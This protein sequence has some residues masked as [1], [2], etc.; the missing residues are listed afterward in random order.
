MD[1]RGH[2]GNDGTENRNYVLYCS[3][4]YIYI[5]L[6]IGVLVG[7][8][9]RIVYYLIPDWV[10]E[11]DL[12][13]GCSNKEALLFTVYPC[14]CLVTYFNFVISNSDYSNSLY[15]GI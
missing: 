13:L 9:F 12:K 10:A 1:Y 4:V 15:K 2:T 11:K 14:Y 3:R 7:A 6:F 5:Y 8:Y